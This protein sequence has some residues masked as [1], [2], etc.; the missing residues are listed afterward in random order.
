[1]LES[2]NRELR[3]RAFIKLGNPL[4]QRGKLLFVVCYHTV[5][6]ASVDEI[7]GFQLKGEHV[8]PLLDLAVF[9]AL[10]IKLRSEYVVLLRVL[11]V[12]LLKLQ[13][14]EPERVQLVFQDCDPLL[15]TLD[16]HAGLKVLF[17]LLKD[18]LVAFDFVVQYL[19]L[20]LS[21]DRIH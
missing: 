19:L 16:L 15:E 3:K 14:A 7:A 12:F 9:D 2:F 13:D 20:D 21:L 18:L 8:R 4:L 11:D 17:F 5:I 1:M 10:V 6:L